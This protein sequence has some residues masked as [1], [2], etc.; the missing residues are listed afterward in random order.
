MPVVPPSAEVDH[1]ANLMTG[2]LWAVGMRWSVKAIGLVSTAILAR[3]LK[4]Q[5]YGVV[6]M[7]FLV[8]GLVETF[9]NTGAASALV[10]LGSNP[11][12]A[13]IN[14]AWSLRGIQ[15]C[16]MALVLLAVSPLAAIYFNEPRVMPVLWV[17]SM[18]LAFM[19]FSNIGMTL[20]YRDLKFAVEFKQALYTKLASV[21][22]TL[23]AAWY[24]VDYRALVSG[25]VAGFVVE[26]FL[27]YR[28]HPYR[29]RWCTECI[30][31]IWKISKWLLVTGIGSFFLHRTDQL[32]AGRIGSTQQYGLYTVG[33]DI[34]GLP[35]GE[36]GPSLTRP[37][38]PILSAMQH[39]WARAKSATLKTLGSVNSITMPLGFG[40]AAVST[41]ATLL[42]LGNQWLEAAP[43]VAG[44]AIIGVVQYLTSPINTLLNV[45]GHV[46]V[47][48]RIVWT[49]FLAFVLL[50]LVL[51]PAYHLHGLML[52]RIG[53]GLLQAAL[54]MLAARQFMQLSLTI[55][56]ATLVRP[57][58]GA[59]LMYG[60]LTTWGN[61]F[62]QP[63]INLLCNVVLGAVLYTSWLMLTWRLAGRPEGLESTAVGFIKSRLSRMRG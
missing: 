7:A 43:F 22:I 3:F 4:P 5:D 55:T 35:A 32:I 31:E 62:S 17:V 38:F 26:W 29:P 28:L 63:F 19:G 49:E 8:V 57:L 56:L 27:S 15:G 30:G 50:A 52:A 61:S 24:F 13:Q 20:A 51:T 59:M 16:L 39:D 18:C 46:R 45:A 21:G 1:K 42:L 6:S 41:Q 37:L 33:A 58:S 36:L 14:S 60:A 34:G 40:L 53:S 9:L 54:M 10:R 23:L 2:A 25:I 48:S 47:Q 11:S 44:F 12:M